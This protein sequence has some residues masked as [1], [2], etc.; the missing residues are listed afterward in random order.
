MKNKIEKKRPN[1]KKQET[2]KDDDGKEENK[3]GDIVYI[4]DNV[5]R[6]EQLFTRDI[7]ILLKFKLQNQKEDHHQLQKV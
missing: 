4:Q 1:L 7:I 6:E 5:E 2:K 3:D